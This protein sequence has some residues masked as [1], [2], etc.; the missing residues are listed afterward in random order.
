MQ[1]YLDQLLATP[2]GQMRAIQAGNQL[3]SI[4]IQE[5][6]QLR[7]LMATTAQSSLAAQMKAE[8][9]GQMEQELWRDMTKTDKLGGLTSKP[10][11]F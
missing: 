4:Q 3:A 5:A 7:E 9:E 2:D 8:K 10:D 6:R 1:A 11:P